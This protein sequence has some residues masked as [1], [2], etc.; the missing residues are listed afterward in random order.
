MLLFVPLAAGVWVAFALIF[1]GGVAIA[2]STHR[3]PIGPVFATTVWG[4]SNSYSLSP[5]CRCSS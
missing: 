2:A 5:P 4:A 1:V 3:L